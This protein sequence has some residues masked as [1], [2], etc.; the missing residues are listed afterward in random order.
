MT[1][2]IFTAQRRML[3]REGV[4]VYISPR[5]GSIPKTAWGR[6]FAAVREAMSYTL[7]RLHL[8]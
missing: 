6:W 8:T 5:P 1:P 4:T 7:Y 3:E 2:T